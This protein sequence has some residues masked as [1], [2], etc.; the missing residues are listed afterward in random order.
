LRGVFQPT[1]EGDPMIVFLICPLGPSG[2]RNLM[3]ITWR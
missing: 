1:G 3:K 2:P